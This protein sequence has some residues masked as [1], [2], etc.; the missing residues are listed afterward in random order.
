MDGAAAEVGEASNARVLATPLLT[1]VGGAEVVA[2]A[3]LGGV[4]GWERSRQQLGGA[5][6]SKPQQQQQK[7]R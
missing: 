6:Q 7:V 2:V 5:I 1:V 4:K 3:P